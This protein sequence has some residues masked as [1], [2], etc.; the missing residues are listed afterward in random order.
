MAAPGGGH[1]RTLGREIETGM[2]MNMSPVFVPAPL[3]TVQY[4]DRDGSEKYSTS[5]LS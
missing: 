1:R 3:G 2:K 4:L 5:F